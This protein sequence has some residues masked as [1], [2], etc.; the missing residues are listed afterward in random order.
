MIEHLNASLAFFLHDLL[1]VMDRGF[2][3][4]LIRT[5]MKDVGS[6]MTVTKECVPLWNIQVS[7]TLPE[8]DSMSLLLPYFSLTLSGSCAATSTTCP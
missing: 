5:H 7:N 2:V 3:F 1:S 6:R 4:T 8:I